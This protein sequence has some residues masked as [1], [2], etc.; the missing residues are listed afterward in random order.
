MKEF[1]QTDNAPEAVGPYSQAIKVDCGKMI[2]C[3]GQ[4]PLDPQTGKIMGQLAAEQTEQCL[5]N[6]QAV[7]HAA[8]AELKDVVKANVYLTNM[9]DFQSVNEVYARYFTSFLPA[10]AAVEVSRLPK[11][12]KVE[13]EAIAII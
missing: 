5:K 8:G 3:S 1:I 4:I 10:R 9:S 6:L 11:D 2:F 7:L 13:I 12:V